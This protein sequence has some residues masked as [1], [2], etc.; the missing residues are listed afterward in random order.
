LNGDI[1]QQFLIE[2]VVITFFGGILALLFSFGVQYL[3]NRAGISGMAGNSTLTMQIT[4]NVM[5]ISF[6]VTLLV[7]I[8]AG[9]LPAKRA[10]NLKP[11]DALRFE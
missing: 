5:I 4:T 9:I 3:I 7:G 11:I 2:S 8:L 10:A 6:T 1:I